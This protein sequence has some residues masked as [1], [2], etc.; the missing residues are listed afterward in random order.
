MAAAASRSV[1]LVVEDVVLRRV[2]ARLDLGDHV[3][4]YT[5][6]L[7]VGGLDVRGL[8]SRRDS[9]ASELFRTEMMK[10]IRADISLH[11]NRIIP[12]PA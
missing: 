5:D 4:R 1:E 9:S 6:E 3:R 11:L 2:G 10:V 12:A 7:G 8:S